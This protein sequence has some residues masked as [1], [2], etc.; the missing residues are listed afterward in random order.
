[1]QNPDYYLTLL[2]DLGL[3]TQEASV[4]LACLRLGQ[5]TVGPI[6]KEARVQR[7]FAYDILDNL[8]EKGI[9][10]S[11]QYRGRRYYS[12]ISVEAFRRLQQEKLSRFELAIPELKTIE[13]VVGDRPRVQIYEG[14]D[15]VLGA[16][17]DTLTLP[18]GGEIVGYS[19]GLGMY[20]DPA[21]A[22]SYMKQRIKKKITWRGLIADSP[23]ARAI[24]DKNKNEFRITR[25][26]PEDLFPFTHEVIVY[27]NKVG[28]IALS[29]EP[30]SLIIESESMAKTQRS[31]FELAWQGAKE[32]DLKIRHAGK[33]TT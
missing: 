8:S 1:M 28:M 15:H 31:I 20:Q 12:G 3:R 33:T 26:V 25:L 29:G 21:L 23:P 27:G 16:M 6:S 30:L 2:T 22:Y 9:V 4:Y 7:T 13:R 5:S 14:T 18:T 24:T 17:E 32:Y 19:A 11:L 10:S